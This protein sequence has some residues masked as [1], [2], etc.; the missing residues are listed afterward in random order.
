MVGAWGLGEWDRRM[1]IE[2]D[3]RKFSAVFYRKS[4]PY[5]AVAHNGE[6]K[7]VDRKGEDE[8]ETGIRGWRKAAVLKGLLAMLLSS[9]L[10]SSS[11]KGSFHI[12]LNR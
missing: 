12:S 9:S 2:T 11:G 5:G 8:G 7:R 6:G 4:S 3:G 10:F 1:P